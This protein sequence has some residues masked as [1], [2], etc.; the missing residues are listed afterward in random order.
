MM[1]I[2]MQLSQR[3][4]IELI[5]WRVLSTLVGA[6][7]AVIAGYAFWPVW[8]KQRFPALMTEALMQTKNYLNK[9][10]K[11]YNK[12]L[13]P[14]ENWFHNRRLT[15]AA[16]NLVF[17][18]VQRMYEEPK[19]IQQQVDIYFTMIGVNIRMAREITSIALIADETKNSNQSEILNNYLHHAD[20]LFKSDH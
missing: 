5:G 15:E 12:E 3:G 19:H 14:N 11:Y 18:S 2:L 16:N 9:V 4:S 8:E 10:I 17:A 20:K 13:L 7:L 6:A 1:V